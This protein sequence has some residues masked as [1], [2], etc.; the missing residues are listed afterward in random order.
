MNIKIF[1]HNHLLLFL[2]L[3][4]FLTYGQQYV[5]GPIDTGHISKNGTAAP[6]G[7]NW[8]ELQNDAGNL[9]ITNNMTGNGISNPSFPVVVADDFSIPAGQVW[10]INNFE[11]YA[12]IVNYSGNVMPFD[13]MWLEI[14]NGDPSQ[15]G[16]LKIYGD[17][18]TN[19]LDVANCE[20]A[21]LYRIGN[22][23]F[24]PTPNFNRRLWKL[25][26]NT[27][28]TLPAGTY[29]IYFK[30]FA[31]NTTLS[32]GISIAYTSVEGKRGLPH[33]NS[34]CYNPAPGYHMWLSD[35]DLGHPYVAPGTPVTQDMAFTLNYTNTL[36]N[37]HVNNNA[38]ISMYPNP[39][40][41]NLFFDLGPT[42]SVGQKTIKIKDIRGVLVAEV[43]N[44]NTI[45]NYSLD[46]SALQS[47]L[48]LVKVLEQNEVIYS[49]KVVK[50]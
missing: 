24:F 21:H 31:G 7:Y 8:S 19:I 9:S 15:P 38:G 39:A 22:S 47:G 48:Y 27:D 50:Y 45:E 49:G 33:Y 42:A 14:W 3:T 6:E 36:G 37:H 13:S 28:V 16:S 26:G 11:C 25:R 10:H 34:K 32:S 43:K 12:A 46:V 4:S 44:V 1:L 30:V 17:L 40:M 29:W 20:N 2:C 41:D 35:D 23:L 5:N 18:T